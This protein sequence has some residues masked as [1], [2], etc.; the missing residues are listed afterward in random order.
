MDGLLSTWVS[1]TNSV[2]EAIMNSLSQKDQE[3]ENTWS[4]CI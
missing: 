4:A 3:P 2:Y 1:L